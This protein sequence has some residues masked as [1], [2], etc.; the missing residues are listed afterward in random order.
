MH[1]RSRRAWHER[2]GGA[3]EAGAEGRRTMAV[4]QKSLVVRLGAG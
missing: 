2:R 4:K 1:R 3:T